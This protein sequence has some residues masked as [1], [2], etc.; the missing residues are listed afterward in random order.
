MRP[1]QSEIA[2]QFPQSTSTQAV[3]TVQ[4]ALWETNGMAIGLMGT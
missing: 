2:Q 4:V 1:N 3:L